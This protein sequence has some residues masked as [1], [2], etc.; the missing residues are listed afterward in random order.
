MALHFRLVYLFQQKHEEHIDFSAQRAGAWTFSMPTAAS[1][2]SK[3]KK[4][5][6]DSSTGPDGRAPVKLKRLPLWSWEHVAV[7]CRFIFEHGAPWAPHLLK[8]HVA[9][10]PE[11]NEGPR[12]LPIRGLLLSC[13]LIIERSALACLSNFLSGMTSGAPSILCG[14]QPRLMPFRQPLR[15]ASPRGDDYPPQ[16]RQTA[17]VN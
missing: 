14:G 7:F 12:T 17:V 16:E 5:A 11:A 2:H 13:L 4:M 10:I 9:F 8:A 6:D 1:L 3:A 15:H